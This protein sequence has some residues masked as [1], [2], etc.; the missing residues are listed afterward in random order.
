MIYNPRNAGIRGSTRDPDLPKA[1][2]LRQDCSVKKAGFPVN[3][4]NL[5]QGV[6]LFFRLGIVTGKPAL[7]GL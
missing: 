6:G 5:V 1:L 3:Q 4:F 7:R 2:T